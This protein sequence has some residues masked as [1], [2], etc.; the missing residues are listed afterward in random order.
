MNEL[1]QYEVDS[2]S[3]EDPKNNE[4]SESNPWR[5]EETL[6]DLVLPCRCSLQSVTYLLQ[7]LR[8][9]GVTSI[10]RV[11]LPDLKQ[12][13]ETQ[14]V[15]EN[16]ID[17][18]QVAELDWLRPD[19]DLTSFSDDTG[20]W[21]RFQKTWSSP[22]KPLGTFPALSRDEGSLSY[23]DLP[24]L[25]CLHLYT[26]SE[27]HFS[28]LRQLRGID[29]LK[30]VCLFAGRFSALIMATGQRSQASSRQAVAHFC[31]SCAISLQKKAESYDH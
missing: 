1:L 9:R 3:N 22:W 8:G 6:L 4:N 24:S 21:T 12:K 11:K 28:K 16:I 10:I 29:A 17:K 30:G 14:F 2:R 25:T 13:F 26:E 18:F 31:K 19:L 23:A 5:F 15:R 27:Y 7:W 20:A